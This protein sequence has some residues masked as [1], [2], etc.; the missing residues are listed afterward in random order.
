MIEFTRPFGRMLGDLPDRPVIVEVGCAHAA[1]G[2]D[3]RS[4]GWS[5]LAFA[6]HVHEREGELHSIDVDPA[7]LEALRGILDKHLPGWWRVRV[8]EGR[9]EEVIG[10]LDLHHVDLLYV[11]GGIGGGAAVVQIAAALEPLRRGFGRVVFDD[12]PCDD[13]PEHW[14]DSDQR[15]SAVWANPAAHG[16]QLEWRDSVCV[17]FRAC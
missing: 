7:H 1:E 16:L 4:Q 3:A 13:I 2:D 14:S 8:Y 6:R 17:A 12:C 15:I 11:D 10:Q 5:S 9:G